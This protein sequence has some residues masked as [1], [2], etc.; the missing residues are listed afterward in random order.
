MLM[1]IDTPDPRYGR[2]PG[3]DGPGPPH[4]GVRTI[5]LLGGCAVCLSVARFTFGFVQVVLLAAAFSA[6]LASI[7][8]LWSLSDEPPAEEP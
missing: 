7:F 2:D 8:S 6:L 5:A 1:L 4:I 3:G